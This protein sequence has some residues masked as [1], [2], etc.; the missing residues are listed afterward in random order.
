MADLFGFIAVDYDSVFFQ[1]DLKILIV[2]R[3]NLLLTL[4]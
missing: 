4:T 1:L 2:D 3:R